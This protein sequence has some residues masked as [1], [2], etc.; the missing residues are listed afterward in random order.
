MSDA[1]RNTLCPVDDGFRLE[2]LEFTQSSNKFS[3]QFN[4]L[5][6]TIDRTK[7]SARLISH[8]MSCGLLKDK[9]KEKKGWHKFSDSDIIWIEIMAKLRSFGLNLDTICAVNNSLTQYPYKGNVKERAEL[10]CFMAYCFC[11]SKPAYLL[12]FQNG[13]SLLGLESEISASK[14]SGAIKD[15]YISIDIGSLAKSIFSTLSV[16]YNDA[17]SPLNQWLDDSIKDPEL[18]ALSIETGKGHYVVEKTVLMENKS[19]ALAA[20]NLMKHGRLEETVFEGKTSRVKI[21]TTK[22]IKK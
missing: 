13:E 1:P 9:R 6:Y 14:Q 18:L 19:V 16:N 7:M 17:L 20:R 4:E 3:S 21:T 2:L 12:V 15:D 11:Q 10:E 8:W 22:H 5:Y